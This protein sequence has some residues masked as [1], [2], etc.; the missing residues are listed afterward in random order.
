MAIGRER[1]ILNTAIKKT[2]RK[3]MSEFKYLGTMKIV[4][5]SIYDVVRQT[6]DWDS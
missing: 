3:Q 4:K 2:S 6:K 1:Y 5:W